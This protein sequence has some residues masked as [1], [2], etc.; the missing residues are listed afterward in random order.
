MYNEAANQTSLTLRLAAINTS[1][2]SLDSVSLRVSQSALSSQLEPRVLL[3][4]A[5]SG[6]PVSEQ[7]SMLH[8][9]CDDNGVQSSVELSRVA[10]VAGKATI[11]VW[12]C[13]FRPPAPLPPPP[14]PPTPIVSPSYVERLH[15]SHSPL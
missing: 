5:A 9:S 1:M 6:L 15:G 13:L 3:I 12:S 8:S 10:L 7:Q 11:V 14:P 4:D 2:L